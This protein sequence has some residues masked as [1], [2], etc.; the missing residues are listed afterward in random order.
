MSGWTGFLGGLAG[1]LAQQQ[2]E[3]RDMDNEA[4][5]RASERFEDQLNEYNQKKEAA[6]SLLSQ[7]QMLLDRGHSPEEIA[8]VEGG[9]MTKDQLLAARRDP[10]AT[11]D[12]GDT[13]RA[14]GIP[15][16]NAPRPPAVPG[17]MS[18]VGQGGQP[19]PA[20][21]QAPQQESPGFLSGLVGDRSLGDILVGRSSPGQRR[22]AADSRIGAEYGMSP[23]EIAAVRRGHPRT[24]TMQY[25]PE[26]LR[27]V[28]IP[29]INYREL[30]DD[31]IRDR[32]N[33]DSKEDRIKFQELVD[34]GKLKEAYGLLRTAGEDTRDDI[35]V[36]SA[37][38]GGGRGRRSGRM[39]AQE[40]AQ[41]DW[42]TVA[43]GGFIPP[44]REAKL[45]KA[46]GYEPPMLTPDGKPIPGTGKD[47]HGYGPMR[48][49]A[50][51][52]PASNPAPSQPS[53]DKFSSM[54]GELR[55][56]PKEKQEKY[57]QAIPKEDAEKVRQRL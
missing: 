31:A 48:D 49:R 16:P 14:F 4:V 17:P 30:V 39:T 1:G 27:N 36:R 5:L 25:D 50:R 44:V 29:A 40:Q 52:N 9:L 55:K 22:Y 12:G 38:R 26:K 24:P 51:Q 42:N 32:D 33:F 8:L 10:Q 45:E 57:L 34:Q 37:G 56:H 20:P 43:A 46:V 54:A 28:N 47:P 53:P 11:P 13:P 7:R 23:E 15:N 3:N 19:S 18:P 35:A 6:R 21:A 41:E 2:K